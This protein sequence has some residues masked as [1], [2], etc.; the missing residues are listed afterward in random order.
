MEWLTLGLF[1]TGL[2]VCLAFDAP[3]LYALAAGLVLFLLYGRYKKFSWTELARMA[4][5]GVKSVRNILITF[6][7]IGVLTAYWRAAGTIPVLV[8]AAS[9]LIRPGVFLLM[10]FLLCCGVSLLTGTSFGTAA[11]M[12][13]ICATMGQAMGISPVLAGGA[14]LSGA[15]FGDRCS[16]VST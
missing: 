11:T 12:G 14:I 2:L 4:F 1:C 6:M 8:S 5:D 3:V 10:T 15:F 9:G 7:L 16:P 13:V